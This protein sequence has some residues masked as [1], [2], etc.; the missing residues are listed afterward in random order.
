MFLEGETKYKT[1]K[2]RFKHTNYQQKNSQ[3]N[4]QSEVK[5]IKLSDS[6]QNVGKCRGIV[7]EIILDYF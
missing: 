1:P 7:G 5:V 4:H 2:I 6:E 3:Q